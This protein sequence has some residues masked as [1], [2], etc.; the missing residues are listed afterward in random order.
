MAHWYDKE[1]NPRHFE[2]KNGGDTTLREA[3]KLELY[4]SVTTIS[5][6]LHKQGLVFWLQQQAALQAGQVIQDTFDLNDPGSWLLNVNWANQMIAK[7]KEKTTEKAD[8]GTEIHDK[9]EV[10]HADPF[11]MT[12]DDQKMCSAVVNCIKEATG[13]SLYDDFIPEERFCN[14]DEGYAGTC[15]LHTPPNDTCEWVLDYKSKDEVDDKTRGYPEQAEQLVA[16]SHGLGLPHAKVGNIFI[17]RTPP[18]DGEPWAVKFFEHKDTD[19]AWLRF[20]HTL[21][22]WQVTKKYG[23]YYEKAIKEVKK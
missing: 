4:P 19:M 3:R 14:T 2:G 23:P 7:A 15:D 9:L 20:K 18:A 6:I 5:S 12:G 21:M 8:A 13:L 10:Y 1:G 22:L 16:Y 17:S 11:G